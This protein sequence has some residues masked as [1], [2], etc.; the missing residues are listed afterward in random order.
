[1]FLRTLPDFVPDHL[2]EAQHEAV[3]SVQFK[4]PAPGYRSDNQH[5]WDQGGR[6]HTRCYF[7]G[8]TAHGPISVRA[9]AR[10]QAPP[11]PAPGFLPRYRMI[12][13]LALNSRHA[14][15]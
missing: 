7:H 12:T 14:K 8:I 13:C 10:W 15:A 4:W 11:A 1:M 5:N 6:Q 3:M 2:R 9:S